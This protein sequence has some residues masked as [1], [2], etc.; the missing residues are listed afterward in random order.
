MKEKY[1]DIVEYYKQLNQS[2]INS[3]TFYYVIF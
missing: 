1:R 2:E 3:L